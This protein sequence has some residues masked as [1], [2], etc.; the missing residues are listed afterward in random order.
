M[1]LSNIINS[2]QSWSELIHTLYRTQDHSCQTAPFQAVSLFA[3][4][5][6]SSPLKKRA[7]LL[8]HNLQDKFTNSFK[9]FIF[10][11]N[12]TIFLIKRLKNLFECSFFLFNICLNLFSIFY[13]NQCMVHTGTGIPENQ[14]KIFTEKSGKMIFLFQLMKNWLNLKK[15]LRKLEIFA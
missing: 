6:I 11:H 3:P 2:F 4:F 14:E 12:S 15:I 5:F 7:K 13:I 8:V 10:T 1:F 9:R